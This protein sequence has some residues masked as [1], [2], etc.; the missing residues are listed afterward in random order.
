MSYGC[1]SKLSQGISQY[2]QNQLLGKVEQL[3]VIFL[4]MLRRR[5]EFYLVNV[6]EKVRFTSFGW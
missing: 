1:L 5:E 6:N 2:N 3:G 4:L